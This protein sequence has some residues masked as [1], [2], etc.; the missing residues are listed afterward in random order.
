[1]QCMIWLSDGL[2][3]E[4]LSNILWLFESGVWRSLNSIG[5]NLE[6]VCSKLTIT[7]VTFLHMKLLAQYHYNEQQLSNILH[8]KWSWAQN[9]FWEW[10]GMRPSR[11][12]AIHLLTCSYVTLGILHDFLF[13]FFFSDR[14]SSKYCRD[15]SQGSN[16]SSCSTI[17]LR[18]NLKI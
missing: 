10:N 9:S 18:V 6:T 7:W 3:P 5:K 2:F 11:H 16:F 12:V 13:L 8:F 1:M 4:R 17:M 14:L 15:T